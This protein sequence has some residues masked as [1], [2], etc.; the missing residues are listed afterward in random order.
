MAFQ[1]G[2]H[3]GSP[4]ERFR[5]ELLTETKAG[6]TAEYD[7]VVNSVMVAAKLNMSSPE[8]RSL[9]DR[10]KASKDTAI[11]ATLAEM[12][13][14]KRPLDE[15]PQALEAMLAKQR[16]GSAEEKAA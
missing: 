10:L 1:D 2:S 3:D 8:G 15:A 7:N 16:G 14:E 9:H 13:A 11:D 6:L 5:A 4:D 12:M